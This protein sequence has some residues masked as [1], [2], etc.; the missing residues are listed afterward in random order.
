VDAPTVEK[1]S[2]PCLTR[3][4]V[5]QAIRQ[6][7]SYQCQVLFAVLAGSGLRISE[8]LAIRIQGN[9]QQTS[10]SAEPSSIKVRS[11]I[12]KGQ[13]LL[14]HTKSFAGVREVDLYPSLNKAIVEFV[15]N[16][17]RQPGDLLFKES[18]KPMQPRSIH[19]ML[20]K[21]GQGFHS[22]RRYRLSRLDN[23]GV[24]RRLTQLW[25]GH[26]AKDVTD[27][28]VSVEEA[29]LRRGW[30]KQI[31]LGFSLD[32]VGHPGPSSLKPTPADH[33]IMHTVLGALRGLTAI[34]KMEAN[35][36]AKLRASMQ[37]VKTLI[38]RKRRPRK[39]LDERFPLEGMQPNGFAATDSDLGLQHLL[40]QR[41]ESLSPDAVRPDAQP[42]PVVGAIQVY[43]R[44]GT[45]RIVEF[46]APSVIKPKESN[47]G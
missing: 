6:A 31:G 17:K 16:S 8:A 30:V 38:K 46:V 12:W 15:E 14:S 40:P 21:M 39:S 25:A 42:I 41:A 7:P 28:Y 4:G 2:R 3:E 43:G 20:K 44:P 35:R 5:E 22:F 27:S 47:L 18:G 1:Q 33:L 11:T 32:R 23:G 45:G 36:A 19:N 26:R 9:D 34:A 24:P 10:W 37:A 29:E 13:E